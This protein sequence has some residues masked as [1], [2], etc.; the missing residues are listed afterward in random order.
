MSH[1]IW[2]IYCIPCKA[3]TTMGKALVETLNPGL[4]YMIGKSIP[5]GH[6]CCEHIIEK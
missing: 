1:K 4:I 5:A 3:H 2:F 6:P